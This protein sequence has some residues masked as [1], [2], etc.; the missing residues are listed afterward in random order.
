MK[1][2][3][4]LK[5]IAPA[6]RRA[7]GAIRGAI[8]DAQNPFFKSKYA[9]LESCWEAV[10]GPLQAEGLSVVQTMG[11]IPEAGPTLITTLLH[12][13]GE[14]ISGEQPACAKSGSPQDLGSALTYAR[15]YGLSAITGL[16]QLDDDA[17]SATNSSVNAKLVSG[18]SDDV[19]GYV[20]R[21]GKF[22][23]QTLGSIGAAEI[24]NYYD[25]LKKNQK[26]GE[27]DSEAI[28]MMAAF[29]ASRTPKAVSK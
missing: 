14:Y 2:S 15:R 17:Q 19:D 12:E 7:Q 24:R 16:I 22:K 27:P 4:S 11:F 1:H 13:S 6:I 9:D 8:K 28:K 5:N 18:T 10:K 26:P 23:D 29:I 3:E 25:F 20:I 21:F